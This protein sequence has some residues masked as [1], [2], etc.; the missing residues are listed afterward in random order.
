MDLKRILKA[1][2]EGGMGAIAVVAACAGG[3]III[4]NVSLTGLALSLSMLLVDIAQ[5]SL[6]ILL[7]LTMISSLNLGMGLT[8]TS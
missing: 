2:E 6:I 3:G 5:G 4:G 1:L 7:I 8:T